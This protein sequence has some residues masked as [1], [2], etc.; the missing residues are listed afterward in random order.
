MGSSSVVPHAVARGTRHREAR[1]LWFMRS[2]SPVPTGEGLEVAHVSRFAGLARPSLVPPRPRRV[3][4]LDLAPPDEELV[5]R[6]RGG[7][8]WASE[9]LYR[10]HVA[11]VM[12]LATLLLR[13]RADAE[14]AV[15]DAF[16]TALTK[17]DHLREP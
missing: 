8:G 15:Q 11:G 2:P 17:L 5:R 3:E 14:D 16:V 1:S 6:A 10:R 7:D 9:A 12:R 4:V 13:R